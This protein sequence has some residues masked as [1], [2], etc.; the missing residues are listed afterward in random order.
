MFFDLTDPHPDSLV[1]D[2]DPDPD[3]SIIIKNSKKNI[4]SYSFVTYL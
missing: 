4:V 2:M 1:R 3:P